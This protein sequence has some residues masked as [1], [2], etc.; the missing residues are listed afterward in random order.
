VVEKVNVF[1]NHETGEQED[2]GGK[3]QL[4]VSNCDESWWQSREMCLRG[5]HDLLV[6]MEVVMKLNGG[7]GLGAGGVDLSRLR[8]VK[9]CRF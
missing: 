5:R 1:G 9:L 2:E 6:L 8:F 4:Q 3:N 7:V